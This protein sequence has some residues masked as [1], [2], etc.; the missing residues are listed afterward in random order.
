MSG[1]GDCLD[2]DTAAAVAAHAIDEAEQR[3]I[4]QHI[5]EC[6]DCRRLLSEAVR[7]TG[8]GNGDPASHSGILP[9][10]SRLGPYVIDLLMDAGGMGLVY[11][12]R[13]PRLD[14]PIALKVLRDDLA[15]GAARPGLSEAAAM[16]RVSHPNVVAVHDVIEDAGRVYVAMELV[17]GGNVKQWL[18]ERRRGWREVVDVFIAAGDGLAAVHDAGVVHGDVKPNN[19]LRSSDGRVMLGDFGL[20]VMAASDA[21]SGS[22]DARAGTPAYMA[23]E[24]RHGARADTRSDQYAFC[25]SLY[26]ALHASLPDRPLARS[27]SSPP[28]RIRRTIERGLRSDPALRFPSVREIV[29][30]LRRGRRMRWRG[31]VAAASVAVA[32]AL[33]VAAIAHRNA[34]AR[35]AMAACE[36]AGSLAT[37]WGEPSRREIERALRTTGIPYAETAWQHV[38]S[39]F[40]NWAATYRSELHAACAATWLDRAQPIVQL[41]ERLD[42]LGERRRELRSVAE[43]LS[44][45]DATTASYAVAATRLRAP[46][47]CANPAQA[48]TARRP[49]ERMR[50][51]AAALDDAHAHL[52]ALLATGHARDALSPAR[53][54]LVDAERLA[55][56]QRHAETLLL[57]GWIEAEV[58]EL[59]AGEGHL[60]EAITMADRSGASRVA[61]AAWVRLLRLEHLRGRYDRLT[62]YRSR[63]EAAVAAAGDDPN[64]RSTLLHYVGTMLAA[65]GKRDEAKAVL[66]LSLEADPAATAWERGT[67]LESIALADEIAGDARSA[68]GELTESRAL[69]EQD[70]G[71]SH[72]RVAYSRESLAVTWFDLLEPA[73]ARSEMLRALEIFHSALGTHRSVAI[74]HDIMGF[75]ELELGAVEAAAHQH[76]EALRIW[77]ALGFAHPRKALSYLG[78]SQ[79]ELATGDIAGAVRDAETA[80]STGRDIADPKDRAMI[81][82]GLARA[83]AASGRDR[84]RA[85]TLALE[86]A[87]IYSKPPQSPRDERELARARRLSADTDR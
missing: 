35:A 27:A 41:E 21:A 18:A 53:T 44:R 20:A 81:A 62:V 23:P 84:E 79:V 36:T 11:V 13:D 10:G 47:T 38:Q 15:H 86:A 9:R 14:R 30:E 65:Q 61:A 51:A 69:I 58:S 66:R 56:P 72:P 60:L 68:V 37:I 54:A 5:D 22:P 31:I 82:L 1:S 40:D 45:A 29:G 32:T 77:E 50:A 57:L 67:V 46:A 3:R 52:R 26:E 6:A 59:D 76:R 4:D 39:S 16:A 55:D 85:R 43:Q 28:R 48:G 7:E 64:L 25:V 80:R 63:A 83:L 19:I 71:P 2:A 17:R 34:T 12:A 42:C 49:T 74:A 33:G 87:D 78:R 75:I 24:Q 70:L 73:R 8:D